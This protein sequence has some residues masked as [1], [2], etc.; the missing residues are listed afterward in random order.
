MAGKIFCVI[1]L[2]FEHRQRAIENIKKELLREKAAFLN[3]V[4]LY[5]KD[6][7]LQELKS[8]LYTFPLE[9]KRVV[10][11]KGAEYLS[12]GVKLFLLRKLKDLL[13]LNYLI[14]EIERDHAQFIYDRKVREDKFFSYLLKRCILR[15]IISIQEDY[16]L[17]KLISLV[18]RNERA[19]AFSTLEK[20]FLQSKKSE[21]LATQI[22]GAL[23]REFSYL[24]NHYQRSRYF[25]LLWEADRLIKEKGIPSKLALEILL[26]K[27]FEVS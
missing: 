22:L 24:T 8:T 10:I 26:A 12:Q 20:M 1:G 11:F 18:R 4:V 14:F 23:T 5:C 15:R 2:D 3:T 13:S 7:N 16:S 21:N 27:L 17:N 25:Q 6:L 9:K 19:Q